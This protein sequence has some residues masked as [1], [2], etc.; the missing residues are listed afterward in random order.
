RTLGGAPDADENASL[1]RG[2]YLL[3]KRQKPPTGLTLFDGP[4]TAT[5]SCPKRVHTAT[6][7]HALFLLNNPFAADRA[8][9][10]A[11]RVRKLAGN[12]RDKQVETAFLLALG[13]KP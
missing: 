9:A 3:M 1:R 5:E 11:A 2:I 8:K 6:P 10:F 4:T 13:R 7:L 12:D